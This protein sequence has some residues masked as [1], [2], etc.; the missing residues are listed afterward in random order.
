M[1]RDPATFVA[2]AALVQYRCTLAQDDSDSLSRTA[3]PS[4]TVLSATTTVT[5]VAELTPS[6]LGG[7]ARHFVLDTSYN[8]VR[9]LRGGELRWFAGDCNK[10]SDGKNN[11]HCSEA[12]FKGP[13]GITQDMSQNLYIADTGNNCIR[14][15]TPDCQVTTVAGVCGAQG[16]VDGAGD[17]ALFSAPVSV[18]VNATCQ[19]L[20]S[21]RSNRRIR[22]VDMYDTG[23][24]AK[25]SYQSYSPTT[26][27]P[28][29]RSDSKWW[30]EK[31]KMIPWLLLG[32]VLCFEFIRF[33]SWVSVRK[34]RCTTPPAAGIEEDEERR[35]PLISPAWIN[36]NSV[37]SARGATIQDL[38]KKVANGF[39]N[40]SQQEAENRSDEIFSIVYDKIKRQLEQGISQESNMEK[41]IMVGSFAKGTSFGQHS[42][43]DIVVMFKNF[44]PR[45]TPRRLEDVSKALRQDSAGKIRS[46]TIRRGTRYCRLWECGVSID[47]LVG[48]S[49]PTET[50]RFVFFQDL[51]EEDR[52]LWAPS[53]SPEAVEFVKRQPE[54][55][56]RSIRAMKWWRDVE[57][58][59]WEKGVR[60]SS[61]LLELLVISGHDN[62]VKKE[63][64]TN[65]TVHQIID[66]TFRQIV[67]YTT[68]NIA[69]HGAS[70]DITRARDR[71][72]DSPE[73]PP[74]IMDPTNP[75]MNVAAKLD[76][77]AGLAEEVKRPR[78]SDAAQK[79]L[80]RATSGPDQSMVEENMPAEA[81]GCP[82]SKAESP[83]SEN[84]C[85]EV[86]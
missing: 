26:V 34:K 78:Q 72:Q 44:S 14:R 48:G 24:C 36:Q 39:E 23:E 45:D 38:A 56:R 22:K 70:Y 4:P 64:T 5:T 30:K 60:P 65:T 67:S 35:M 82:E 32:L 40:A 85:A 71:M 37:D 54:I 27:I 16:F 50:A 3:T 57:V 68:L 31:E 49:L 25:K 33:I 52:L 41:V 28:A 86:R 20:V 84:G 81:E 21:D 18:S 73:P 83:A 42:D 74:I 2:F 7:I 59:F 58:R 47:I 12:R 75:M 11:G 62:L 66:E 19:L 77:W 6:G 69:F 46:S 61:T 80:Y 17:V 79:G 1:R 76:N 51:H 29:P 13:Q 8:C 9:E 10:T 53:L 43:L 15:I 63:N 55:V